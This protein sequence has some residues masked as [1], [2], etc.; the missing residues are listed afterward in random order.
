MK[1]KTNEVITA[2]VCVGVPAAAGAIKG[3]S[4]GI[5]IFGGAVSAPLWLAGAGV[6]LAG[7][8]VYKAGETI[9]SKKNK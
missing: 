8:G 4:L 3:G 2:S 6:G 9:F 7:Y 1:K 5:A